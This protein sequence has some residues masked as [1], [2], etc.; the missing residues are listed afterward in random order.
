VAF[1]G[2][3]PFDTALLLNQ[4]GVGGLIEMNIAHLRERAPWPH[5]NRMYSGHTIPLTRTFHPSLLASTLLTTAP[6][7]AR[8]RH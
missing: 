6:Q 8:R 4:I 2:H 1:H 3:L 7:H 5:A